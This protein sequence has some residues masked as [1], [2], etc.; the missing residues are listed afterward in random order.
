MQRAMKGFHQDADGHWV[1]ELACGHSQHVRH[2]P[3]LTLRPWVLTPEGRSE[4]LGQELECPLCDHKVM[5]T[6]YSPYKRTASFTRETVP[7]GLLQRHSTKTGVWALLHVSRGALEFW[8]A[9][10]GGESR[11][12]VSAGQNAVIRPEV[13][14]RVIPLDDLE[15]SV[16]FWHAGGRPSDP[17]E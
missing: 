1:A 10:A 7:P 2:D 3:P 5:P 6:G 12:L 11:Q 16:E 8:E 17:P 4:R 14:H 9:E 13:E 15:F